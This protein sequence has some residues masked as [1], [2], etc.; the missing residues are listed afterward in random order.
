MPEAMQLANNFEEQMSGT[1]IFLISQIPLAVAIAVAYFLRDRIASWA[2]ARSKHSFDKKLENLKADL[3]AKG[4][5]IDALR[6]V[7][8]NARPHGKR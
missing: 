1:L 8:L 5:E 2:D 7:P 4:R 3:A 6:S